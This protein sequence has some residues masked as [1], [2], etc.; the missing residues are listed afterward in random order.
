MD[1]TLTFITEAFCLV[2]YVQLFWTT[3]KMKITICDWLL[4]NLP[5]MHKDNYL[6]NAI[7]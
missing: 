7:E 1:V 3:L 4:E 2:I 6:E 5:V